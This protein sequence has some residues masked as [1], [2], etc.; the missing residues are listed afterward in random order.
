MSV[1]LTGTAADRFR[2]AVAYSEKN[3]QRVIRE[4]ARVRRRQ[5]PRIQRQLRA[6]EMREPTAAE[7]EALL[8][9]TAAEDADYRTAVANEQW[10]GRL[11]QV[12]GLAVIAEQNERIIAQH[13]RAAVLSERVIAR[14]DRIAKIL[15]DL[16][17]ESSDST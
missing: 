14:L 15:E 5:L 3:R 9:R 4:F 8:E 7:V 11:A 6:I 16:T 10:G 2:E 13:D 12:Y 1:S 17:Y